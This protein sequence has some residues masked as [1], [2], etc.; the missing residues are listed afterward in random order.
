MAESCVIHVDFGLD[1]NEMSSPPHS[2]E[3]EVLEQSARLIG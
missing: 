3:V 1:G 2:R